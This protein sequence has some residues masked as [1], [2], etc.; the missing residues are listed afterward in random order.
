MTPSV[1]IFVVEDD[2]SIQVVLEEALTEGGYAVKLAS[3]AEDAISILDETGTH[4]RALITDVNWGE[5]LPVGM[6]PGTLARSKRTF[7]SST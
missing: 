3:S 1:L 4:F 5:S 2:K 7:R 6:W